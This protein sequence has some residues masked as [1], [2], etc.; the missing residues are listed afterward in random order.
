MICIPGQG[1]LVS[2]E[3]S[4][5]VLRPAPFQRK[6]LSEGEIVHASSDLQFS[7]GRVSSVEGDSVSIA[8]DSPLWVRADGS[9]RIIIVQL[10]AVPMRIIG[11][12][13][14]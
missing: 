2:E 13:S 1:S 6:V 11:T 3:V 9:S 7:V 4:N 8:W 12:V 10:D 5:F 14:Q